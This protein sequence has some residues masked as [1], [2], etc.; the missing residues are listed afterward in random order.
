MLIIEKTTDLMTFNIFRV[1][2]LAMCGQ[3]KAFMHPM[4]AT[5]SGK[6]V[7][8][9]PL[10]TLEEPTNLVLFFVNETSR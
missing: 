3:S 8:K 2:L 5:A 9:R 4:F 7:W 1:L 10:Q 6:I